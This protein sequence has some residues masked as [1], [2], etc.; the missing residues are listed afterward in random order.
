MVVR[1][2][3]LAAVPMKIDICDSTGAG[4]SELVE[5]SEFYAIIR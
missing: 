3:R 5:N 4:T 1:V 2:N